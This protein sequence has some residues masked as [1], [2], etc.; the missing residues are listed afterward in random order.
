[1]TLLC[2]LGVLIMPALLVGC[3]TFNQK[4]IVQDS[5]YI[6]A[7]QPAVPVNPA[8]PGVRPYVITKERIESNDIKDVA[9]V[10]FE[11]NSWLEFAKWLHEYKSIN[12]KLREI[13]NGYEE[14]VHDSTNDI[15]TAGNGYTEGAK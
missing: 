8:D 5:N 1:M 4:P 6:T 2:K 10:G 7:Y 13:I 14:V 11:Y 15:T 9:Y 3:V 12:V